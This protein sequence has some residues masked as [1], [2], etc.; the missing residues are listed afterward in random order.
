ME[1]KVEASGQLRVLVAYMR[2]VLIW[3]LQEQP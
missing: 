2:Q 3:F 1:P